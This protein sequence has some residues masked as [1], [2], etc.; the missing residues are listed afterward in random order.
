MI[1]APSAGFSSGGTA[2]R[3]GSIIFVPTSQMP[4]TPII[5]N[6]AKASIPAIA[7]GV[8]SA[9]EPPIMALYSIWYSVQ[10]PRHIAH[11]FTTSKYLSVAPFS[12]HAFSSSTFMMS[13][14]WS[15]VR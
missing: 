11:A 14:A 3:I 2:S 5:P 13:L 7:T 9:G 1:A 15:T 4:I 12:L 8:K 10:K 6:A